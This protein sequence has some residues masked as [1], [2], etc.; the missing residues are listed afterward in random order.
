V[1]QG[2]AD[3]IERHLSVRHFSSEA[4]SFELVCFVEKID[5][6]SVLISPG[7]GGHAFVFAELGYE[8]HRRGYNVFIM[9]RHGGHTVSRLMRRHRDALDYV[10]RCVNARVGVYA[11]G[12]VGYVSFYLALADGFM[13]SL[14]CENSPAVLT[15][16]T[17]H[18]ALLNDSGPWSAA[19]RRRR[20]LLPT[21][22][23]LARV[24]PMMRIPIWSY[25]DWKALI[26]RRGHEHAVERRLVEDGYLHDPDF[27]RWYPLSH[28]MSLLSTPPPNP[29]STLCVPTMFFV[30]D[31]G[32]TP[33]YVKTLYRE[34]PPA[35]KC[36]YE[37]QGS[38]YWMLSHPSE[39]ADVVCEWF[40]QTV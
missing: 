40:D 7:S 39:A 28:V 12:L 9:P 2:D 11:E 33:T 6:P 3:E 30:A 26:D 38:V 15:D 36:L 34:L 22:A 37:V 16:R 5:M 23:R 8:L 35:K 14:V 1:V 32:P 29:V 10:I 31:S 25:L 20:L 24:M 4:R 21:V 27:D 18:E 13:K 17:Y 19:A